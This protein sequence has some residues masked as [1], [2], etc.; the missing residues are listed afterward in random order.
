MSRHPRWPRQVQSH[1]AVAYYD[2]ELIT[3]VKCFMKQDLLYKQGPFSQ[4]FIF[5]ITYELGQ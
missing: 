3:V 1:A 2:S 4:H 5:F